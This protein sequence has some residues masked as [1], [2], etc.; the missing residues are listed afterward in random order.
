MFFAP[1]NK[2]SVIAVREG[3]WSKL[4]PLTGVVAI[5]LFIVAGVVGGET[6]DID[7][8]AEAV[9]AFYSDDDSAQVASALLLAYG[10]LFLA[11]FFGA[12]RLALRGGQPP[13]G[14]GLSAVAFAGGLL[15]VVG[16]TL[17]AGLNFTLADAADKIDP[18]AVQAIHALN[19]DLFLTVAVG[20]GVFGWAAGIAI[21]R[22]GSLLPAPLGWIAI[23]IGIAAMT[24]IGFFALLALGL[25]IVAIAII[26]WRR[27][28]GAAARPAPRREP[29]TA[30]TA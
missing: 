17:F 1:T 7:E 9:V 10:C 27:D 4:A 12:L 21:L 19:S 8:S 28:P 26:L 23:V 5:V 29:G 20:T 24:P 14:G 30:P 11:F 13:A 25:W 6:P 2:G 22:G 3:R 18:T 16:L 15:I